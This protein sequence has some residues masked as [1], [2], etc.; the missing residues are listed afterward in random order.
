MP[1][2]CPHCKN[3]IDA[4]PVPDTG[5]I[6]CTACGSRFHLTDG[7]TVA[8]TAG[9]AGRRVSRFELLDTVGQGAFGTVFKARDPHLDRTVAVKVP[10]RGNVGETPADVDRFLREARSAAQLR[11]P[12]IVA[13]HEVGTFDDAPYLV[14]DFVDGVTLADL[15]TGRRPA[16]RE[17]ADLVARVAD[18]LAYA[19]AHGVVHRDIKPANIMIRPDGAPVV[20]DFGLAKRDA[21]ETT[22]TLD[23]QVLGT[24]AYMSPEQARGEGHAAD[25]RGDVYSLGVILYQLLTG[26]LPF[27]GNTRMLLHQVLHDDPK[28]PRS[29]NDRIPRDLDTITS[30]AMAKDPARRYQTAQEMADDLRRYVKGEPI[31]A[32]PIGVLGKTTRWAKRN[33]AVAGLLAAVGALLL[34]VAGVS[35]GFSVRLAEKKGEAEKN[36]ADAATARDQESAERKKAD[37]ARADAETARDAAKDAER[38]T[39]VALAERIQVINALTLA[40]AETK[41]AL[42]RADGLRLAAEASAALRTDPGLALLLS[43][44]GVRKFPHHLTFAALYE[45]ASECREERTITGDGQPVRFARFSPDGRFVLVV[46]DP[47]SKDGSPNRHAQVCVR[48]H[49]AATGRRVAVW[50]GFG[51]KVGALDWSRDGTRVA[52][53]VEG[54]RVVRFAD[55]QPPDLAVYT[56]QSVYVFDPMTG[57]DVL[58]VG[59]HDERVIAVRFSPDGSKLLT[60]SWDGTAALWDAKTGKQLHK[61]DGHQVSLRDAVFSPDGKKVLTLSGGYIRHSNQDKV[62]FGLPQTGQPP[63]ADAWLAYRPMILAG[64]PGGGEGYVTADET[65]FARVWDAE[66]G[67]ELAAFKKAK[68][69]GA[70]FNGGWKPT[71]AAFSPDGTKVAIGFSDK[72]AGIWDAAANDSPETI[73]LTGHEGEITAITFDKTGSSVATACTDQTARNWILP[74]PNPNSGGPIRP[75]HTVVLERGIILSGHTAAVWST[76]FIKPMMVLTTSVDGTARVWNVGVLNEVR[77]VFRGHHGPIFDAAVSPDGKRV[78]TAGDSTARIW[79]VDLPPPLYTAVT[80]AKPVT[81]LA[82][83]P[84]GSKLLTASADETARLSDATTGRELRVFGTGKLLGV[85]HSAIFSGDASLVVTASETTK[86]YANNKLINPSAVHV[87]DAATGD[88]KHSFPAHDTGAAFAAF[89]P[90]GSRLVTVDDGFR[91]QVGSTV[92]GS[93]GGGHTSG[94]VRLWDL[95]SQRLL[96]TLQAQSRR[97]AAAQFSRDGRYLL[98]QSRDGPDVLFDG[99]AGTERR[100]FPVDGRGW[101]YLAVLSPDGMRVLSAGGSHPG[102]AV[103]WDADTAAVVANLKGPQVVAFACFSP[104]GKRLVTLAGRSAFVWDATHGTPLAELK[105]H[106]AAVVSAAFSPDGSKLLTGSEDK[107]AAVWDVAAGKPVAVYMGHPGPV[108]R[109]AY[110]PD[111][112]RVATASTDGVARIWPLD[113]VP[114]VLARAPRAL[115]ADERQRYDLPAGK[116]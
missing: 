68:A 73:R 2:V 36:A 47:A 87:W 19:H 54:Y 59:R 112:S 104:D 97:G 62:W 14:S 45:A 34:A 23:G 61:L 101:S 31:K 88:D 32:R 83:S 81:N 39:G 55:K 44:E 100:R 57:K 75:G 51:L 66:T 85:V 79:S 33:P 58:H 9:P 28:P 20:M 69:P 29:L 8:W 98:V 77:A 70:L 6:S 108:V 22:M 91:R 41:Q 38:K 94:L 15:L 5:E 92:S 116:N 42:V 3:P 89:S 99:L 84:D 93:S 18:A 35:A 115:T 26:E 111:G 27:R 48:V 56:D 86:G 65:R 67:K 110:S 37:T 103:L 113:V 24:P 7:N 102:H 107:T 95:R 52:V 114:G 82:F 78:A 4:G 11:H 49:D 106:G 17:A 43:A 46:Q 53:A 71:A 76:R 30:K 10:R 25:G 63:P 64:A 80:H 60:A 16:P 96:V 40:Q 74:F 13:V 50:P 1:L 21:G 105:G 90:E 109:V 72:V 12:S